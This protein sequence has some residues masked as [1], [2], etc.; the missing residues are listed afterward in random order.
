MRWLVNYIRQIF[1]K[2]EWEKEEREVTTIYYS[3]FKKIKM[4]NVSVSLICKKC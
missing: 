4:E 2:H 1:C 3:Y